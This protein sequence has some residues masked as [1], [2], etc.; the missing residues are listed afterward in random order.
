MTAHYVITMPQL[1][2]TMTEG[3]VVSWEKKPGDAIAR[4]DIVATVETDK[5]I[6]DVE[7]FAD[8]FLAGPLAEVGSTIPVGEPLGYLTNTPGDIK[9]GT[10]E[11]VTQSVQADMIPH[12][13]GV[14]IMMPQLSDTMTEGVVVSWEKSLG[15][16]VKRGDIVATVETDKAIMDVEVFSDGYLSGPIATVESIVEVGHAMGFIVTDKNKIISKE[17]KLG[18]GH[19]VVESTA[20]REPETS[21]YASPG[22]HIPQTTVAPAGRPEHR[23]VSPYARKLAAQKG[24]ELTHLS[25]TGPDGAI[26]ASD[27]LHAQPSMA[28]VAHHLPQVQVPG[29]GRAMSAMEKS[30]AH[31]MTAALTLPTFHV[32]VHA[33]PE[34]LSAAAKARKIS[35]TVAI[36]KAC[37]LAMQKHPM[38]NN[39]YQPIDR[40][41]ERGNH[42]F[43]IAVAAESGGLVV[44]I[45]HNIEQKDLDTLQQEWNDIVPR[46]RHRKLTPKDYANPTFTISNMGMLGVSHFTA[47][48]TPGIAAILAI[49]AAGSEGMPLTITA[50]HRVLNGAHVATYLADL[51]QTIEHPETWVGQPGPAIPEGAWDVQVAILGGGPGGEDC[52]R[53]LSSHGVKVVM[54]NK[55]PLPGGECL[56]RGCIPSKAWRMT[57]DRIRDRAHDAELGVDNTVQ[58][59]SNWDTIEARRKEVMKTRG[60]LALNTDKSLKV[61]VRQGTAS[62]IDA[63]TLQ[64]NPP[65]GESYRLSFGAAV[66]A[67]GAPPFVPPSFGDAKNLKASGILTSDSVWDLPKP[68]KRLGIIGAGAIGIEMAQ[69]MRDFG[70]DVILLEAKARPLMEVDEEIAAA[71][72]Q[73]LSKEQGLAFYTEAKINEISG[74]PGKMKLKFTDNEN[75]SH[76][77]TVDYVLAATGKR[78]DTTELNLA[79]VGVELNGAAIKVDDRG[80]T[81]VPHIFAVGDVVGGYMLAHTAATQGRVAAATLLGEDARYNQDLD[82]GV[83]FSRPQ[84]GFVGLTLAQAKAKGI[85]AAEVK[86]PMSIDAKAMITLESQGMIKLVAN[87]QNQ[88]IIGVHFLADH[89]DALIGE[90]VLMVSAGLT[91]KQVADAIHPHPTQTELLGELARKLLARL[92]RSEKKSSV[93]ASK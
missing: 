44:P 51:K 17:V 28:E 52:A 6:M 78:P 33:H 75:N 35:L 15:D 14:P 1:S 85:D 42:D 25:A 50:D 48:P 63:H 36:A 67:T 59:K 53:E 8:G 68:P 20:P 26:V 4:A 7:V 47:I 66:I 24:V 37:S 87:K 60:E 43:G 77:E 54:I 27:V 79:G 38:M 11:V 82:C 29:Q 88:K 57:A 58:A 72:T 91:L 64:V 92:R 19:R 93:D 62:F 18:A 73:V 80:R 61:D 10:N 34:A 90:A 74:K 40:I 69:I 12:D 49:S 13:A 31:S 76:E 46:A 45:L 86:M 23:Q 89:T 70:V 55:D 16:E 32:T 21:F 22:G 9:I 65:E 3:V 56:W 2:D 5:A 84:A 30:V 81:N 41:V 83:I 39:T 71:L